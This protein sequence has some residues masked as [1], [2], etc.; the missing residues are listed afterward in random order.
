MEDQNMVYCRDQERRIP[1]AVRDTKGGGGD[2]NKGEG[3]EEG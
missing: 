3:K 2:E 1:P